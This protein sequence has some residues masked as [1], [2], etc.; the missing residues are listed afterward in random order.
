MKILQPDTLVV[1]A[2]VLLLRPFRVVKSTFNNLEEKINI[3]GNSSTFQ[4]LS[5]SK[6]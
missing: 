3:P 6:G 2:S 5:M 1:V 4:I